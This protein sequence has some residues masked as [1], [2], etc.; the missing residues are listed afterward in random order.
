MDFPS[1][2][3]R[4]FSAGINEVKLAVLWT[5]EQPWAWEGLSAQLV[6]NNG[7]VWHLIQCLH[8]KTT[9]AALLQLAR[10]LCCYAFALTIM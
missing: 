8:R 10:P 7:P 9:R 2:R 5:I 1:Q 3:N 6:Q 4:C